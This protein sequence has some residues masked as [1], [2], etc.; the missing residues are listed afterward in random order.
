MRYA[1]ISDIHG[2]LEALDSV[3]AALSKESI[4]E[5]LCIGDVIGYGANPVECVKTVRSLGPK[6][7]VAGNHEWG[8]TGLF[9]LENFT[10]LAREAV[11]WTRAKIGRDESDYLKTFRLVHEEKDCTLVHGSLAS[12]EKFY[13]IFTADDAYET[14][15]LMKNHL[16]FVGHTH[17]AGI[18]YLEGDAVRGSDAW[19]IK[20][21]RESKY[22]VNIGSVGQPRDRD[23][24]S[25]FAIY[26]TD[27]D[28]VEIRRVGYDIRTAQEKILKTGLPE[29]LAFRLSEGK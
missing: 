16:C 14:I 27:K 25:A 24:R 20:V 8:V 23:P 7:L 22:V 12:P 29:Q 28:V 11:L 4:D 26:D 1:L 21:D 6:V 3:L 17:R 15:R 19:K 13:Y 9:G 2:N 18:F 10:D 5:Y